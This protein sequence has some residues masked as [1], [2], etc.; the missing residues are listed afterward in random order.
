MFILSSSPVQSRI[1]FA[2]QWKGVSPS[3]LQ[4]VMSLGRFSV[5][6]L[7]VFEKTSKMVLLGLFFRTM[8]WS[9]D[10]SI[11]CNPVSPVRSDC[12]PRLNSF[13][14]ANLSNTLNLPRT[15]AQWTKGYW[16]EVTWSGRSA[17]ASTSEDFPGW[18]TYSWTCF[19]KESR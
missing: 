6:V 5:S 12:T 9:R 2:K 11:R 10:S 18:L 3:L 4:I 14:A 13:M 1:T 16:K 17:L 19:K 7:S 8:V 15:Q